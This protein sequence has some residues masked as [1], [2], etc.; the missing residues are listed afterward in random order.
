MCAPLRPRPLE[1]VVKDGAYRIYDP[2][3]PW[4]GSLIALASGIG[5]CLLGRKL[6]KRMFVT[7]KMNF[8]LSRLCLRRLWFPVRQEGA[9]TIQPTRVCAHI[10]RADT[11]IAKAT[12]LIKGMAKRAPPLGPGQVGA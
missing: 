1:L 4:I 8:C 3:G 2:T 9:L 12:T 10:A 7:R 11:A 6:R 5:L